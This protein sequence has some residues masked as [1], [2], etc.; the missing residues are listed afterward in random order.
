MVG[1]DGEGVK[2]GSSLARLAL[3]PDFS[4]MPV[5][6]ALSNGKAQAAPALLAATRGI[7]PIKTLKDV[8]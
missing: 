7:H 2:E 5:D 6:N 4:A 3:G 8:G 1:N